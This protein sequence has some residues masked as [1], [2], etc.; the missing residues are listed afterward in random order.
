MK[1]FERNNRIAE[2]LNIRN[3]KQVE[4]CEKAKVKKSSL[5]NWINQRWQPKQKPLM[6]MA[7]VLDVSELWLAGYDVAMERPAEQKKSDEL[8]KLIHH[9]RKDDNLCKLY[10]SISKLTPDQLSTVASMVNEFNKLN[11]Q[12]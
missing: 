1:E 4:L 2:A 3:M 12:Q 9:L 10:V 7:R 6:D 11:S 8:A 5:S